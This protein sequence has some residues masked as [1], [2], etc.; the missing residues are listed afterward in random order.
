MRTNYKL[1]LGRLATKV[2]WEG[3]V[4]EAIQYGIKGADIAD[5]RVAEEWRQLE[6]MWSAMEPALVAMNKRLRHVG[7]RSAA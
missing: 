7:E 2:E 4:L 5:P 1:S 3:G 6:Q